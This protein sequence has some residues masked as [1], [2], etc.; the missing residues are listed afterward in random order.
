MRHL[1]FGIALLAG[2]VG[3]GQ[4]YVCT[5]GDGRKSFQAMPCDAG[6]ASEV[7][8]YDRGP[9][10]APSEY[11]L[12][13]DTPAYKQMR[14]DNRRA[15]LNREVRRSELAIDRHSRSMQSE[16]TALRN[17]KRYAANNQAGATWE[18]SIS[19][20]MQAVTSKYTTLMDVERD[21]LNRMRQELS[22]L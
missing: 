17:K 19:T 18:N 13:T 10:V 9:E 16:L 12:S 20:E 8:S 3:A 22:G 14:A 21:N 5:D 15:E 11:R 6:L 1:I 2:P 7:R 4:M